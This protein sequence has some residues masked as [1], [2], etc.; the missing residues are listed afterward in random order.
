MKKIIE[1]MKKYKEIIMY[2]IFGVLTTLIN[3]VSFYIMDKLGIALYVNNT[4]AWI[5]SVLFAFVTN[6]LFVF[7]SKDTKPKIIL[8]EGI[9]FFGFRL[10]SY[11]VDMLCIFLLVDVFKIN[12]MIAKVVGNIIVIIIN[13]A[14]SKLFIFKK[15]VK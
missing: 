9:S 6:K 3:I 4:I 1:L 14:F 2:L 5:L 12:K 15:E 10:L 8:K 11:F 13:Y 7:E